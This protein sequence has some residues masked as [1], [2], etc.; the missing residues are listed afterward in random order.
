LNKYSSGTLFEGFSGA[1]KIKIAEDNQETPV[2][3]ASTTVN[4]KAEVGSSRNQP[5]GDY[6]ATI[7]A[8]ATTL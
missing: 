7:T 1:T 8:T 2:G 3:G 4:F 5:A 6:S